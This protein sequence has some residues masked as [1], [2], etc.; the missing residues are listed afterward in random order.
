MSSGVRP[1][2][3]KSPSQYSQGSKRWLLVFRQDDNGEQFK[4]SFE[5]WND[6]ISYLGLA[7]RDGL[8]RNQASGPGF[9][10]KTCKHL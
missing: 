8:V 6:A 2:V 7:L 1:T 10:A 9:W 5:T 3:Y 4:Q